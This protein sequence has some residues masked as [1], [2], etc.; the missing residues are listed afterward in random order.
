LGYPSRDVRS[1]ESHST[2]HYNG[3][4]QRRPLT[5]PVLA[6]IADAACVVGLGR[7]GEAV[8][9]TATDEAGERHIVRGS[10]AYFALCE[11]V[12]QLGFDLTD[13]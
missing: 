13:G 9:V 11:L 4:H 1:A 3:R 10:A 8:V 5:K 6:T 12:Q 2:R 7:D